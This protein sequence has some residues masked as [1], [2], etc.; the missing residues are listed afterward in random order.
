MSCTMVLLFL[1]VNR[2]FNKDFQLQNGGILYDGHLKVFHC[3]QI[4]AV[5]VTIRIVVRHHLKINHFFS[6]FLSK[7]F[8]L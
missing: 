2:G 1:S 7:C 3:L 5:S 6:M 8:S 4:Y